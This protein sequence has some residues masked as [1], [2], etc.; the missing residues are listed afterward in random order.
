[1]TTRNRLLAATFIVT[2]I[3]G[4]IGRP[5]RAQN[6]YA[7]VPFNQGSLFYRYSGRKPPQTTPDR[8]TQRRLLRQQRPA[9]TRPVYRYASPMTSPTARYYYVRPY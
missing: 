3:G 8:W 2:S 1:M 9:A 7:D 6:T 5:A 4:F